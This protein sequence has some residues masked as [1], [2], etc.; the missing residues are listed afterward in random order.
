MNTHL[1]KDYDVEDGEVLH[2]YSDSNGEAS[3]GVRTLKTSVR[4]PQHVL[5][6][7]RNRLLEG[8]LA[9]VKTRQSVCDVKVEHTDGRV[10]SGL[11]HC[12]Q[13]RELQ[14]NSFT[15]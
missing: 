15:I 1:I 8:R 12:K 14:S 9:V 10:V 4:K 13:Y 5:Q 7:L 6:Q 11:L 2:E 3:I